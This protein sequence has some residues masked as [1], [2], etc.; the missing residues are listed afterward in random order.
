ML[1]RHHTRPIDKSDTQTPPSTAEL[2]SVVRRSVEIG[3]HPE[4][5][6][7]ILDH[8]SHEELV[9]LKEGISRARKGDIRDEMSL[10]IWNAGHSPQ[11]PDGVEAGFAIPYF[12]RGK[13]GLG[14]YIAHVDY[15]GTMSAGPG[16]TSKPLKVPG[17][18]NR[19]PK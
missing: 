17:V 18:I 1:E 11:S 7:W 12:N 8:F 13:N 5:E 15:E 10:E 16:Q 19:S 4:R 9:G 2:A 14:Q 6:A 3:P